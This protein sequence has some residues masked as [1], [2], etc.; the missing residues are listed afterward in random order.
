MSV[1]RTLAVAAHRGLWYGR[2]AAGRAR[3]AARIALARSVAPV[4]REYLLMDCPDGEEASGLFS[5]VAAVVGAAAEIE[6]HPEIYA[7]LQVDFGEHGLYYE[8]PRGRNWWRY[9]FEPLRIGDGEGAVAR[10]VA[11]WQHDAFAQQVEL[12]MDRRQAAD[13][14][15]RHVRVR[16]E[17]LEAA[18][19]HWQRMTGGDAIVGVHYR[20]T[21]KWEGRPV[22]SFDSVADA[23]E[24]AMHG[25]RRW[26]LFVAT[27]E[28]A[29]IDYLDAAFNGRVSFLPMER[30][31]DRRPLHKTPGSGFHKG[32]TAV[33][34]CLLLSRCTHLVRTD[35]NLSLFAT[36]FNP[37]LPVTL[38]NEMS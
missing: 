23:I 8:P 17:I 37:Q 28:Q 10:R 7:G 14:T 33:L 35:S 5:E 24:R 38:L 6:S 31:H 29:C 22:V 26:R 2:I 13:L 19:T 32:Q 36:F 25:H 4:A 21:D 30:S 34:D 27:D 3:R 15:R 20:G 12:A 16:P 18:E 1:R 9:F 11:D